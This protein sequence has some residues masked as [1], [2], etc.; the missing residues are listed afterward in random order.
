[1]LLI[2]LNLRFSSILLF[3]L[4]AFFHT[5]EGRFNGHVS[6]KYS[7]TELMDELKI[8]NGTLEELDSTAFQTRLQINVSKSKVMSNGIITL[9]PIG[10][11]LGK[12]QTQEVGKF[13]YLV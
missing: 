2:K 3:R 10:L 11:K 7:R 13:K 9:V 4:T 1:M 12:I 5:Q 8:C 6:A